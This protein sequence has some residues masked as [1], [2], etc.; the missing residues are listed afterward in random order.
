[1][2]NNNNNNN[3]NKN[4]NNNH[5]Q[6]SPFLMMSRVFLLLLLL[7]LL[8]PCCCVTAVADAS[9]S[10][11]SSKGRRKALPTFTLQ[12]LSRLSRLAVQGGIAVV[13]DDDDNDGVNDDDGAHKMKQILSTTGL[14]AV[15]LQPEGSNRPLRPLPLQRHSA[16]Q[17]LCD[18]TFT[19]DDNFVRQIPQTHSMEFQPQSSTTTTTIKRTSVATATVGL[20]HPLPLPKELETVCGPSTVEAMESL[21][22][23]LSGV[24]KL[25]VNV[26]D[27][28]V[29]GSGG[30][31]PHPRTK[32]LLKDKHF[33]EYKSITEIVE[34]ANHLEHFHVYHK[35]SSQKK[36]HDHPT[37][38]TS[39]SSSSSSSIWDWHTDAGLFLVFLPAFDCNDSESS[40]PAAFWYQD[41][42][43][44]L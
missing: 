27:A 35:N 23:T 14:F 5:H 16:F 19:E 42:D 36:E 4:K 1:M 41:D 11:S 40:S 3:K 10:S 22:D 15:Q 13:D 6:L 17:G 9:S 44:N 2:N 33:K 28:F 24:S 12:E 37:T 26:L 39:T 21:R 30:N 32:T 25:F 43:G 7:V 20:N 31:N 8:L 38:T 34:S 29:G 18:C